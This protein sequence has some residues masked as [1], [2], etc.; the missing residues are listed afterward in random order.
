[1]AGATRCGKVT[2]LQDAEIGTV[3]A[4]L[5]HMDTGPGATDAGVREIL[6]ALENYFLGY[7]RTTEVAAAGCSRRG[8]RWSGGGTATGEPGSNN[9]SKVT[10]S[11][12]YVFYWAR[13]HGS[14]DI[15]NIAIYD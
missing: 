9:L 1:V 2:V 14:W 6:G 4:V 15:R 8:R 7:R 12:A 13:A 5:W 10:R 3:P 11:R